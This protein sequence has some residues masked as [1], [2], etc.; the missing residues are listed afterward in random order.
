[1]TEAQGLVLFYLVFLYIF[2]AVVWAFTAAPEDKLLAPV[3]LL[4]WMKYVWRRLRE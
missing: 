1:M 4:F 2:G 3:W